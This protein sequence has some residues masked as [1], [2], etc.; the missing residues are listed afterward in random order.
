MVTINCAVTDLNNYSPSNSKP[1]NHNRALHLYR[2][3]GLGVNIDEIKKAV[4]KNPSN[5]VDELIDRAYNLPLTPKPEW[6]DW[7]LNDYSSDEQTRGEQIGEQLLNFGYNWGKEIKE[8]GL[9]D[10]LALFWSNHF[11]AR[12]ED[13]ICPSWLYRYHKILQENCLGN[14]KTFVHDIG[15][16]PGMLVFL[17]N[18]QNT[19][20]DVNENYARELYELFTLGVD[21]GYTQ[22][23]IRE[24][25]RAITGYNSL[26]DDTFCADIEFVEAFWDNGEKTIFGRTGN[27]GYGD[28]VNILFE[29]RSTE[30]SEYICAKLYRHFVNPEENAD[31]IGALAK[32]FR[33]NDFELRPVFKQLF[34][35]EHFFDDANIGA[36]IP[37]H[38]EYF[39]T[40]Y[41]EI[42]FEFD[43]EIS[44]AVLLISQEFDQV[45]FSP[46]D[47]AGWEGNR[48]WINSASLPLRWEGIFNIMG[49]FFAKNNE[50]LEPL[51]DFVIELVG[52]QETDPKVITKALVD[53]FTPKGLQFPIEYDEALAVFKGEVPENYFESGQWNLEWEYAPLQIFLLVNHIANLPE[54]QLK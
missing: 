2:R 30:I 43:Q 9:R 40:F 38:I 48:A 11:V 32:T 42:G 17:D 39:Y 6:A 33:D 45:L 41:N 22:E 37:S 47:V 24:T 19:R 3:I 18:V 50:T 15:I 23:D 4:G 29:E 51:R 7:D 27:W 13:Y 34:K 44:N 12:L 1:W 31:V 28:V 49:F 5:L 46:P 26:E 21:N 36:I 10:K 16:T 8:N 35:S 53:Y 20:F 25:A 52:V 14:F 54:F